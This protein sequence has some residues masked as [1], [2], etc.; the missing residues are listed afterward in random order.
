MFRGQAWGDLPTLCDEVV[1]VEPFS[2]HDIPAMM[3]WNRDREAQ[4]WFDWP[5]DPPPER[6]RSPDPAP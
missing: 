2:S 3:S 4:Q 1:S 5:T 6:P